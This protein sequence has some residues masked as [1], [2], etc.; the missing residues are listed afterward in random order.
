MRWLAYALF[1]VGGAI[2]AVNLYLSFLRYPLYAWRRKVDVYRRVSGLPV[3]GSG[4]VL[5]ALI[6]GQ[7]PTWAVTAGVML[8]VLDTGGIHWFIGAM[9]WQV[10]DRRS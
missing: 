3:L 4:L 10:L 2:C 1:G 9:A 8:A 6:L 7:P 5:V